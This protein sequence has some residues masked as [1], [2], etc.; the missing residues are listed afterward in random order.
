M[1]ST[2]D[3]D[4]I[5]RKAVLYPRDV[6]T[7]H[8]ISSVTRWRRERSGRLPARDFYVGGRA[9]GWHVATI[10]ASERLHAA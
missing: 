5:A 1:R 3:L 8:D 2:Y 9:V 7:R 10:E 6:E 4:P